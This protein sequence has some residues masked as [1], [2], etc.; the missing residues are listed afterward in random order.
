M[1]IGDSSVEVAPVDVGTVD[2]GPDA[3]EEYVA[4]L[5]DDAVEAA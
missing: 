1:V 4:R 2:R 5:L 3:V